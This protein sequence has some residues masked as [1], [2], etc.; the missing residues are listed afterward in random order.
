MSV[1]TDADNK[2][3][4]EQL[5]CSPATVGKWRKRF[6]AHRLDGLLDEERPGRPRTISVDQ[7]ET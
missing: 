2:T 5:R 4:V 6:I 1:R 7:V 3:V